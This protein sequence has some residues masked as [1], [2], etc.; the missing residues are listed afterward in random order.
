[1]R[2]HR[3]ERPRTAPIRPWLLTLALTL[4][5]TLV[6]PA[7]TTPPDA[8]APPV[9]LAVAPAS[10]DVAVGPAERL[11]L[12]VFTTDRERVVGG[13]VTVRLAHLGDEP[14]GTAVP[15][16]PVT[17]TW[18]PVPG[19][20]VP[21][22]TGGPDV[23]AGGILSGAYRAVVALDRPG[24]WGV[25]VETTLGDGRRAEGRAVLRVLAAPEVP[26]VGDPAPRVA[27]LTGADVAAGRGPA[28]A[29]D[30]RLRTA[31]ERD[32]AA[33]LHTVRIVEA[34]DAG[35]PFVVV[36]ATPVFCQSLVCGPLTD[37]LAAVAERFADRADFI[38]L[39]VWE[40]FEAQRLNAAA[41]AWIQTAGG[42]NEP[43]VFLVGSDG[44]IAAR[45][46]NLL[47]TAELEALLSALPRL[48]D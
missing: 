16:D 7:C 40:D 11:I 14:G 33:R 27:N 31:A 20:D 28:A 30:S 47:D 45:W 32:P 25:V 15:G 37:H 23:V 6:L 48:P 5:L 42:G 19:L 43:W 34:L 1:M 44:R 10:F 3:P 21:R 8:S 17:A 35:R 38:H 13:T 26:A 36:V 12:A 46:D 24:F 39:E 29:L 41:A 2:A 9:E 18:L 4:A 22:P